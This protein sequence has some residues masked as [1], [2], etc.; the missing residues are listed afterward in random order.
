M[1]TAIRVALLTID[2]GDGTGSLVNYD[3]QTDTVSSQD[4]DCSI[5]NTLDIVDNGDGTFHATGFEDLSDGGGALDIDGIFWSR[6]GDSLHGSGG[7][8]AI[9]V[10]PPVNFKV[11][12]L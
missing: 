10:T 5:I 12:C 7:T 4:Q 6:D 2:D 11:A 9:A 8:K 3:Y 1:I